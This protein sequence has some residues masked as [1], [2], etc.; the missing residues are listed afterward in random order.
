MSATAGNRCPRFG[1]RGWNPAC[2][3][4]VLWVLLSGVAAPRVQ[5]QIQ[6]WDGTIVVSTTMLEIREGESGSYRVQLSAEPTSPTDEPGDRWWVMP[7]I[8]GARRPDGEYMGLRL[9]PSIGREFNKQDWNQWKDISIRAELDP[10]GWT[11]IVT[12]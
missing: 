5:A 2:F 8:N 3:T 4:I 6:N 1:Y 10:G 9:T 12:C 7:H 11:G